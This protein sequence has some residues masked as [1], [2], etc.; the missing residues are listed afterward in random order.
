MHLK[1]ECLPNF[2][3]RCGLLEHDLKDCPQKE[4]RGKNGEM[5]ELQYGAWMRGEP[6]RRPGWEPIYAKKNEG[7]GMRGWVPEDGNWGLKL[8]TSRNEAAVSDKSSSEVQALGEWKLQC[9]T[10]TSEGSDRGSEDYQEKGLVNTIEELPKESVTILVKE[11][12]DRKQ[13]NTVI[14]GS[15]QGEIEINHTEIPSLNL[16]PRKRCTKREV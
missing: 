4:E 2:C 13:T 6:V 1:Y 15:G 5:G 8:Q 12:M 11:G 14:E 16:S 7:G 10:Q 9:T 3:H